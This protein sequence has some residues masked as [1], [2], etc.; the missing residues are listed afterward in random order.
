MCPKILERYKQDF[1]D[2]LLATIEKIMSRP[3]PHGDV[4]SSLS[5]ERLKVTL[6]AIRI[7]R[8]HVL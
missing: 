4:K 7:A 3:H 1:Y 2:L 5:L 6:R 8:L